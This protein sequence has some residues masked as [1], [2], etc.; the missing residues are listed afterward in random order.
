MESR[1]TG[2]CL[3]IAGGL[4]RSG[5][6]QGF[7]AC[8]CAPPQGTAHRRRELSGEEHAGKSVGGASAVR[9]SAAAAGALEPR[10][11]IFESGSTARGQ[12]G[13]AGCAGAGF[14]ARACA[15][16]ASGGGCGSGESAAVRAETE[17]DQAAI[18]RRGVDGGGGSFGASG[19]VG[20]SQ[21][22]GARAQKT[23]RRRAG[24]AGKAKEV[25]RNPAPGA[26]ALDGT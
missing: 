16:T 6:G 10:R 24:T 2:D 15:E 5:G 11:R 22:A 4:P 20:R 12:S 23:D 19:G 7:A 1:P 17:V 25:G 8:A 14:E 13:S 9:D 18:G 3:R 21:P 26:N